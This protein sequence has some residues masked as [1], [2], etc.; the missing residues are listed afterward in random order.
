[1]A[2]A[3]SDTEA[4]EP[5]TIGKAKKHLDWPKWKAAIQA[6]LDALTKMKTWQVVER[7]KGRNFVQCKWVFKIKKDVEGKI[8]RYKAHLVAKGFTQVENV[9]YYE[10]WAPVTKLASI[11]TILALA[12]RHDW[13]IDMFDFHNAFLNGELDDNEE[14][15][16]EQL[17]GHE[18]R[19]PCN[20]CLQLKKSL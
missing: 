19:D 4:L 14:V 20:F 10:T 8:E 5:K 18:D 2:A 13:D 11:R 6:E 9:D 15:Y 12:A 16:M 7:P 1:M 3:V 17:P